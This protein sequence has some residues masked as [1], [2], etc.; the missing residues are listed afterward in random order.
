M[1]KIG[2]LFARNYDGDQLVRDEVMPGA[3][4]VAKGEGVATKKWDG[5][6]A[7]VQR[8]QLYKRFDAKGGKPVP[9]GFVPAQE[10]DA[11]TGHWPG[12]VLVGPGPE[13]KWFREAWTMQE[14]VGGLADGTYELIGPRVQGNPENV[15]EHQFVRHGR[16]EL[17]DA[18]R[19]FDGLKAYLATRDIEGVVWHHT[20]GRMAK[21]K[22]RDF[23]L[24]R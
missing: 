14:R 7:L 9:G 13:D 15:S 22:K 18:P 24:K 5:T 10:P 20:D 16:E 2:S 4:W 11:V 23:G 21:I 6:A 1:K 12:W 17:A 8:G 3:E 19:D